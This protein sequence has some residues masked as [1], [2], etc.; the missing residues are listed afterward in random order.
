MM[1]AVMPIVMM[2]ARAVVGM[3]GV[4]RCLRNLIGMLVVDRF[5]LLYLDCLVLTR[6]SVW[7]GTRHV[8]IVG[9]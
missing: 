1:M 4:V 6:S 5:C 8:G 3:L 2:M 9:R 7:L